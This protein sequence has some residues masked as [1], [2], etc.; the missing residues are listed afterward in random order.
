MDSFLDPEGGPVIPPP[1][2]SIVGTITYILLDFVLFPIVWIL[3]FIIRLVLKPVLFVV[4]TIAMPFRLVAQFVMT[5][6]GIPFMILSK[7]E[8][9]T[10]LIYLSISSSQS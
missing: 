8:V 4:K 1:A 10:N 5:V 2:K 9:C 7:F 3:W 6:L